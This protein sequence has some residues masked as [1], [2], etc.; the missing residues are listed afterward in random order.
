MQPYQQ[1]VVDEYNALEEKATTLYN[2]LASKQFD[3]LESMDKTLLK[4]Q[5]Y[6]MQVYLGILGQR[7]NRFEN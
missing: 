6:A 7:T 1:R 2:F 4:Q 5:Y 3:L